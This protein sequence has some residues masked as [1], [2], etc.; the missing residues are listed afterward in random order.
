MHLRKAL[1][2]ALLVSF[3]GC[4]GVPGLSDNGTPTPTQT[5]TSTPTP[6]ATPTPTPTPTPTATPTETISYIDCPGVLSIDS[7]E[8]VTD[9]ATVIPYANLSAERQSEFDAAVGG[10]SVELDQQG[11]GYDFWVGRP[12]VRYNGSV[13]R[14]T[15]AIC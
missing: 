10:Q 7:V 6:T 5:A 12:Y 14:A 3:A 4:S 15:V 13:Y 9:D 2:V 1:L 8:N 11:D